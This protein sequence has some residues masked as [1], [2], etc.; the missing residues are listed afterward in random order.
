MGMGLCPT[1]D[2]SGSQHKIYASNDQEN[3][4]TIR[5]RSCATA[6]CLGSHSQL[7]LHA[8]HGGSPCES[9]HTLALKRHAILR[10]SA[11]AGPEARKELTVEGA[12][13]KFVFAAL[14]VTA[15]IWGTTAA[16]LR[17]SPQDHLTM[18]E[19]AA[20]WA[21]TDVGA[22]RTWPVAPAHMRLW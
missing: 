9:L 20:D 12:M 10:L 3:H 15:I 2:N 14:V 13:T 19:V 18:E 17:Q 6:E 1:W 7:M 5:R 8:A 21:M 4:Q 11:K 22:A 16:A